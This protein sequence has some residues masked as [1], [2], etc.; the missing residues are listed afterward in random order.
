MGISGT[1]AVPSASFSPLHHLDLRGTSYQHP[2]LGALKAAADRKPWLYACPIGF[3]LRPHLTPSARNLCGSSLRHPNLVAAYGDI[4]LG[5]GPFR[6]LA[7]KPA[8]TVQVLYNRGAQSRAVTGA[9]DRFSLFAPTHAGL[10]PRE[11]CYH[12]V[13]RRWYAAPVA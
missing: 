5:T 1:S 11:L 12:D 3:P 6:R 2:E 4:N 7:M 13:L 9:R 8:A 10:R